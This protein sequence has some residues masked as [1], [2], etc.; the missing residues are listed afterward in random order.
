MSVLLHVCCANCLSD[1]ANTIRET[2]TE[3]ELYWAN[4]NIH[5]LVEWRRRRKS[6]RLLA[7]RLGLKLH[8]E[9]YGLH[10]FLHKIGEVRTKNDGRCLKCYRL[11]LGLTAKKAHSLLVDNFSSTLLVSKLQE[12]KSVMEA[13]EAAAKKYGV[14]FFAPELRDNFQTDAARPRDLHLYK[15]SYCGCIFSE[16][17]RFIDS[18]RGN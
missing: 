18:T 17:E 11:R 3:V 6:V 1:V 4:P 8:E 2:H 12:H 14:N 7:K 5:P 9:P 15:Q 13:G 16:E 10:R